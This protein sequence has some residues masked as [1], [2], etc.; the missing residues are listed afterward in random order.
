VL[1][2]LPAKVYE[3]LGPWPYVATGLYLLKQLGFL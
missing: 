2:L 1:R 3:V